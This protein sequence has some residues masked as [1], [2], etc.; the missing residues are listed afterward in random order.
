M[1]TR[2]RKPGGPFARVLA[3]HIPY[4][5][6]HTDDRRFY[7]ESGSPIK[8][9]PPFT[10]KFP[11]GPPKPQGM[12]ADAGA[13]WVGFLHRF[14][15]RKRRWESWD[16]KPNST[17]YGVVRKETKLEEEH[18]FY[19]ATTMAID[20]ETIPTQDNYPAQMKVVENILLIH[21][22]KAEFLAGKWEIRAVAATREQAREYIASKTVSQLRDERNSDNQDDFVDHILFANEG[23]RLTP[24]SSTARLLSEYGVII[25]GPSYVDFDLESGDEEMTN[26]MKRQMIASEDVKTAGIRKQETI[27]KAEAEK[28]KRRIEAE[29]TRNARAAEAEGIRVEFAARMSVPEGADLSWAEAV[30]SSAPKFISLGRDGK[31]GIMV[32]VDPDKP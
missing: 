13:V 18:I 23:N 2:G 31:G 20:L 14:Y 9:D 4:W 11:D 24:L 17:E 16:L 21:P 6:Y 19:F 29:G 27:V 30:K 25:Q 10:E 12:L 22:E 3:G 7:K 26:A 32:G 8:S 15:K 28:E 5:H 1:M